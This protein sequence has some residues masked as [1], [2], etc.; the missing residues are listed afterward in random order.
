MS[1]QKPHLEHVMPHFPV[2][3]L[4]RSLAF[5]TESLG[6]GVKWKWPEDAPTHAGVTRGGVTIML[7]QSTGDR[8][9]HARSSVY[10]FVDGV[11]ELH[12]ELTARVPHS[13]S[14]ISNTGYDM[15]DF[16]VTD[17]DGHRLSFGTCL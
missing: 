8:V 14:G 2:R 3:S 15:R 11:D 5:Y 1:E 9:V 12:A 17:P 13:V 16:N 4:E 6:W 10:I 7:S